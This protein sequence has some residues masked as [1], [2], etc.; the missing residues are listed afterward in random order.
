[1]LRSLHLTDSHGI[2]RDVCFLRRQ[3]GGQLADHSVDEIM[4]LLEAF[5]DRELPIAALQSAA[6]G[7]AARSR[8][9]KAAVWLWVWLET[10]CANLAAEVRPLSC[11]DPAC[12][13]TS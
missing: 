6:S 2:L 8:V 11:L 10:Y 5:S 9:D 3:R 13:S 4:H 12:V 7:L 1:M